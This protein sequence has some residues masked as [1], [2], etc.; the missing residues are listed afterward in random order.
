MFLWKYVALHT[1]KNP[2]MLVIKA[3]LWGKLSF[4]SLRYAIHFENEPFWWC[5]WMQ[6]LHFLVQLLLKHWLQA[7]KYK[8]VT[9]TTLKGVPASFA[10]IC[11]LLLI[12][13]SVTEMCFH[14]Y[15]TDT[16]LY[17]KW[18]IYSHSVQWPCSGVKRLFTINQCIYQ[19][20]V[21]LVRTS[22]H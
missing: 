3:V 13:I 12:C 7:I 15:P 22:S 5:L 8:N 10:F 16:S 2:Q 14:C 1:Q 17:E 20:T 21:G 18:M 9:K 6:R 4:D 11:S 19:R